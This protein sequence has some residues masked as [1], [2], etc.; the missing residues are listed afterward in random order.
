MLPAVAVESQDLEGLVVLISLEISEACNFVMR[1]QTSFKFKI[2]VELTKQLSSSLSNDS[3]PMALF[4]T[5]CD[6]NP[7]V[8]PDDSPVLFGGFLVTIE[9]FKPLQRSIT[10]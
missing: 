3:K 9:L 6:G 2:W 8:V 1:Y 10:I 4:L 7:I 5:R